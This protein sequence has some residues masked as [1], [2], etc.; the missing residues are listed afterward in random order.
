MTEHDETKRQEVLDG[1]RNFSR[2]TL[3]PSRMSPGETDIRFESG[4]GM[5]TVVGVKPADLDELRRVL[6][7]GPQ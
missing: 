5:A 2:I 4:P 1:I 6:T 7:E 3:E